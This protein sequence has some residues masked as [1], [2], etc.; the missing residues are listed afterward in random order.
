MSAT[1]SRHSTSL[2]AG[3]C[4]I[5]IAAPAAQRD[6]LIL[7]AGESVERFWDQYSAFT[8][9]EEVVQRKTE[10][11]GKV[12]VQRKT[13]YDYLILLQNSGGELLVEESRL[14]Q[15][16]AP[17]E[18]DRALLA[19]SGFSTLLL[20]LHPIFRESFAF[21]IEPHFEMAPGNTVPVRFRHI[22]GRP[23]PSAL[24]LRTRTYPIEWQ[25][26]AWIDPESGRIARIQAELPGPMEDVGMQKLSSDV[27]YA[28]LTADRGS[29]W[30]PQ[31]A[32]IEA[33]TRRQRWNNLHSFSRYRKFTVDTEVKIEEPP[34]P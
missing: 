20:I 3:L 12:I 18:T 28:P 22:K 21:S 15:G 27:R 16:K 30:L 8:C 25:G 34:K 13:T 5:A 23:S 6:S 1:V 24:Q 17:K 19:T 9:V 26:T 7:R 14:L 2:L 31:T 33:A 32:V 11:N 4:L 29:I 10:P